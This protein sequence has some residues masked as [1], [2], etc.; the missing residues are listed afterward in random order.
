MSVSPLVSESDIK[1]LYF[2]SQKFLF[3][4][5]MKLYVQYL[6]QF[7]YFNNFSLFFTE[8]NELCLSKP[9]IIKES[10]A[11]LLILLIESS[12][13]NLDTNALLSTLENYNLNLSRLR[14]I[15]NLFESYKARFQTSLRSV[16]SS[17]PKIMGLKWRLDFCIKVRDLLVC[18][19]WCFNYTHIVYQT[20]I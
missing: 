3:G 19:R 2:A 18:T 12:R 14:K 1:L 16:G 10:F 13:H 11:S 20:K 17:K 6:L 9:D 4:Y 15:A 7:E 8:L 5:A